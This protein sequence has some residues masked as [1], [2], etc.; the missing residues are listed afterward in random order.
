MKAAVLD[1]AASAAAPSPAPQS[2]SQLRR[3]RTVAGG[4]SSPSPPLAPGPL[5]SFLRQPSNGG[6]ADAY[7]NADS[8]AEARSPSPVRRASG[9][10]GDRGNRGDALA[11]ASASASAAI[12]VKHPQQGTVQV[13]GKAPANAPPIMIADSAAADSPVRLSASAVVGA[14]KAA[15][16]PVRGARA[17]ATTSTG[18]AAVASKPISSSSFLGGRTGTGVL[19]SLFG[20]SAPTAES[21]PMKGQLTDK[22]ASGAAI[23]AAAAPTGFSGQ[24]QAAAASQAHPR[25]QAALQREETLGAIGIV[26]SR[27]GTSDSADRSH[28][29]A[30]APLAAAGAAGSSSN[31]ADDL[32]LRE[33]TVAVPS[34]VVNVKQRHDDHDHDHD[35]AASD[36]GSDVSATAAAA[37][38]AAREL[39][40]L[41]GD[42]QAEDAG[43]D[44]GDERRADVDDN[45]HDEEGGDDADALDDDHHD[46]DAFEVDDYEAGEAYDVD[47]DRFL[48]NEGDEEDEDEDAMARGLDGDG[49]SDSDGSGIDAGAGA[50]LKDLSSKPMSKTRSWFFSSSS[51][52]TNAAPDAGS[53]ARSKRKLGA[54]KA[55]N[56]AA[57][58]NEGRD[59]TDD[60]DGTG[61][62]GL[63]RG[64]T[65][66]DLR[67]LAAEL[68]DRGANQQA[69]ALALA[70]LQRLRGAGMH[71]LPL[72]LPTI[73]ALLGTGEA[74]VRLSGTLIITSAAIYLASTVGWKN[75]VLVLPFTALAQSVDLSTHSSAANAAADSSGAQ[76]GAGEAE[77][78]SAT[79]S[80]TASAGQADSWR[81]IE[82]VR[83]RVKTLGVA[84]GAT[85]DNGLALPASGIRRVVLDADVE[86]D[87]GA[88]ASPLH[89]LF[90]GAA[91][92]RGGIA[93]AARFAP[94]FRSACEEAGGTGLAAIALAATASAAAAAAAA[95]A[96]SAVPRLPL[97][98]ASSSSSSSSTSAANDPSP[99]RLDSIMRD[100]VE[101]QGQA[102]PSKQ[103]QSA[104]AGAAAAPGLEGQA[105]S[106]SASA[107]A[108]PQAQATF[109]ACPSGILIA[110]PRLTLVFSKTKDLLLRE[111]TGGGR[112]EVVR[113]A[114]E[115]LVAAEQAA[116][117]FTS[118]IA[119]VLGEAERQRQSVTAGVSQH[120][121]IAA[122]TAHVHV[123]PADSHVGGGSAAATTATA[124]G[125]ASASH[126]R[127]PVPSAVAPDRAAGV[128]GVSG[129]SGGLITGNASGG[130]AAGDATAAALA[131][132]ALVVLARATLTPAVV[133]AAT[134]GLTFG[135]LYEH[136]FLARLAQQ[137]QDRAQ[138]QAAAGIGGAP[139]SG[140]G[141]G[142]GV[143]S[144]ATPPS[145]PSA[146][147][148]GLGL[149]MASLRN[150]L[151]R[152]KRD[153][154][155]FERRLQLFASV[156]ILRSRALLKATGHVPE[157]LFIASEYVKEADAQ[158]AVASTAAGASVTA[159]STS[160]AAA[161][162]AAAATGTSAPSHGASAATQAAATDGTSH[163]PAVS[164]VNSL[165]LR[166]DPT[167]LLRLAPVL[168]HERAVLQRRAAALRAF[169]RRTF[170]RELAT[171]LD[172]VLHPVNAARQLAL[173][174]L[175]WESPLAS[176]CAFGALL[177]YAASSASAFALP[178]LLLAHALALIAYGASGP[179]TRA[180]VLALCSRPRPRRGRS[181][182]E[183][184]RNFR[185]TL[186]A[187]Q[188]RM[189]SANMLA[190]RLRALYTWRDPARSRTF[191]ALLVFAAVVLVAVPAR[192]LLGAFALLQLTKPLRNPGAGL[193]TLAFK[194]FWEGIPVPSPLADPVYAPIAAEAHGDVD[195]FTG[196]TAAH[197]AASGGSMND[198][199]DLGHLAGGQD[200]MRAVAAA[201]ERLR[202]QPPP[203]VLTTLPVGGSPAG[204]GAASGSSG[205]VLPR[206]A[207]S[208]TASAGAGASSASAPSA[209]SGPSSG[210][211]SLALGRRGSIF[212]RSSGAGATPAATAGAAG[213]GT[214]VSQQPQRRT[215][216]IGEVF[217]H[218]IGA[219]LAMPDKSSQPAPA[220]V[221]SAGTAAVPYASFTS[222]A[223][224]PP[225]HPV[226]AAPA[227]SAP[228]LLQS[229]FAAGQPDWVFAQRLWSGAGGNESGHK[230]PATA[231]AAS[232]QPPLLLQRERDAAV[233][234]AAM[235]TLSD[236]QRV[237][238]ML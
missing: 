121:S 154:T 42:P 196:T 136:P 220:G 65:R 19:R 98:P 219:A 133:R 75:E 79:A 39:S 144:L 100:F 211:L 12:M 89:A 122:T 62:R 57:V 97:S 217:G 135:G 186:A 204:V 13:A 172:H 83:T 228:V 222:G 70:A 209:S 106:A 164:A 5:L 82:T 103:Q 74:E 101:G 225:S 108:Q 166:D 85:S 169:D 198:A 229:I 200:S 58:E 76:A 141:A 170:T 149:P 22:T 230:A 181:L 16:S 195:G 226:G 155:A 44:E 208:N 30:P 177:L 153:R 46:A 8:D 160:A 191:V 78:A 67:A 178:S 210:W 167:W 134:A 223:A 92:A 233:H 113:R 212:S 238:V 215:S 125:T 173:Y 206:A 102:Q 142:A 26:R 203:A 115:E 187:N 159:A 232:Q 194:R 156:N 23:S 47:E 25:I 84:L 116:P 21:V 60:A 40:R 227:S 111:R 20:R 176:L 86:E 18:V 124:D 175:A 207:A 180:V 55:A 118:A 87:G 216:F 48:F 190:L 235:A 77:S 123:A 236:G 127:T 143:G 3:R 130:A 151:Q 32:Q 140:P 146:T 63:N 152:S 7:P 41:L 183:K 163:S 14:P 197:G 117:R 80:A 131:A 61:S 37:A 185:D 17:A 112:R 139:A 29:D 145:Q 114:V 94:W 119:T 157:K 189:R 104:S 218:R 171:L 107:S 234:A 182:L 199:G 96:S 71:A 126:I 192:V 231:F 201:L 81:R 49:D 158:L 165:M 33:S 120:R 129:V 168:S 91:A 224:A 109:S 66:A 105:A 73:A 72:Y 45:H 34:R 214:T 137:N 69:V 99:S 59:G 11:S 95:A 110:R 128:P 28:D 162:A 132:D 15:L 148:L 90:V 2:A 36:A 35:D 9:D 179:R 53:R 27:S 31:V 54:G 213:A 51:S 221:S 202:R 205:A 237:E 147:Y 150:A 174:L 161:V 64:P 138:L 88:A 93:L 184:L 24:Q 1:A 188:V 193:V 10:T 68:G 56:S 52:A 38:G 50:G 4:V 43:E 6:D